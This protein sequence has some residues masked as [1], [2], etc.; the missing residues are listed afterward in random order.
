MLIHLLKIRGTGC[1]ITEKGR[2]YLMYQ[3]DEKRYET[4]NTTAVV[5]VDLCCRSYLWGYGII[6]E[7]PVF[8][9]I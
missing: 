4:M 9:R 8:M 6:S 5:P 1:M 2:N 3:A 7:T